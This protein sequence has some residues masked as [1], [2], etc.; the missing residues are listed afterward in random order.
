VSNDVIAFALT[1]LSQ[2]NFDVVGA[3]P[4][5]VLGPAG[6]DLDS[7]AIAELALRL[8]DEFGVRFAEEDMEHVAV[9]T[10]GELA[11]EVQRRAAGN[12]VEGAT[13]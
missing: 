13:R 1:S 7:L 10:L 9:M 12:R 6:V 4:D 8:E 11:A 3:D 2:M 5:T